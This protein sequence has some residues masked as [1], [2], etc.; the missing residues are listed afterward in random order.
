MNNL[1][2]GILMSDGCNHT[3]NILHQKFTPNSRYNYFQKTNGRKLILRHLLKLHIERY[4]NNLIES[5]SD[6]IQRFRFSIV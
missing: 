4:I 3:E 2:R 6:K 1:E 5:L